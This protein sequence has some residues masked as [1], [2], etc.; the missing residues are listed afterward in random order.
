MYL[1][2]FHLSAEPFNIAPNPSML[3]PSDR[4][5]E[6]IGYLQHGLAGNGG[7]VMLTGEVG[8]GKT[9]VS[10][11]VLGQLT[12]DVNV[13]YI[14]NP[15][16]NKLQLLQTVCEA[17]ELTIKH[18]VDHKVLSDLLQDFLLNQ[19]NNGKRCVLVIDEAQ[20]L[21]V[22]ALELLRLFT[23]IETNERKLLQI[24]LIGQPELQEKLNK[25]ELRQ[26]AQRITARY[27]LLPLTEFETFLYINHRIATV[28]GNRPLF[29]KRAMKQ[30]FKL[31]GGTPRKINLLAD[32][33]LMGA[34]ALNQ[35][36]VNSKMVKQ[37]A[38]EVFGQYQSN[39]P[40]SSL[41]TK[42]V[43]TALFISTLVLAVISTVLFVGRA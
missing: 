15:T 28:G 34:F 13:A 17:F 40:S 3:F 38:N 35:S 7:F 14:L 30:I 27:H 25:R 24:I 16:L 42:N 41:L 1:Q 20:H 37:A 19:Y 18:Q 12:N 8:T 26:L 39:D 36:Q 4:H 9:M 29:E 22:D 6:A 32:R 43:T 2:H 21:S 33:A 23:N 11:A 10:R 31:S 5:Q